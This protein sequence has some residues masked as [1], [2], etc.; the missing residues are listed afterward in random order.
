MACEIVLAS[1]FLQLQD[2]LLERIRT[3]CENSPFSPK[4]I[5][6]PTSTV[7]E[8]CRFA[9][10]SL[11]RDGVLTGVRVVP[12]LQF[13]RQLLRSRGCS[14]LPR[15]HPTLD[16]L[17]FT[18]AKRL[19]AKPGIGDLGSDLS[20]WF[21]LRPTFLDLADGGF[22]LEQKDLLRE[23]A[24][25][26]DLRQI[27]RTVLEL[28]IAWLE[29]LEM[30]GLDWEPLA[31][32]RLA[33]WI[34]EAS[35]KEFKQELRPYLKGLSSNFFFYGFYD[36]TDV[37]TQI[38]TGLGK[39]VRLT[40][41][42]PHA[43]VGK[44]P[45][46][47]FSFSNE[48]LQDLRGQFG[49]S[50][51][52]QTVLTS[53][54]Q[55]PQTTKFF[56]DT[57]PDGYCLNRP[58]FLTV[59]RASSIR[60]EVL[61]A[62]VQIRKW[63]DQRDCPISLN[64][65]LVLAP[66]TELYHQDVCEIFDDFSI[67]VRFADQFPQGN[68]K[69]RALLCLKKLWESRGDPEWLLTL[70]RE[71][72]SLLTR[73]KIDLDD[74]E[75][76]IRTLPLS[77][78]QGWRRL[79]ELLD[80]T[81]L[82]SLP[83][84]E[85][86]EIALIFEIVEVWVAHHQSSYSVEQT[87]NLM[88]RISQSWL[89]DPAPLLPVLHALKT[90]RELFPTLVLPDEILGFLF[91]LP[92]DDDSQTAAGQ[93]GVLF[94]SIMRARGI[95]AEAMVIL[96]LSLGRFPARIEED[97]LLSDSSRERLRRLAL[98]VG[99]RLA[100]KSQ[101]VDEMILLFFL[102]N[103]SARKIHWVIPQTDESGKNVAPTPWVQHYLH[104]WRTRSALHLIPRG[105]SEQALH[106]YRLDSAKGSMLPPEYLA[107]LGVGRSL[108]PDTPQDDPS[109]HGLVPSAAFCEEHYPDR[110][111]VTEL[112][113]LAQ[114]PYRFY[115]EAVAGWEAIRPLSFVIEPDPLEWGSLVHSFFE[116]LLRPLLG[117]G[118]SLKSFPPNGDE[119]V[120]RNA[121]KVIDQLPARFRLLPEPLRCALARRMSATIEAY[122]AAIQTGNCGDGVPLAQE[123]KIRLACPGKPYLTLSG[124][125][126]RV[127]NRGGK[128]HIVD[129]KTGK[130]PWTGRT[131]RDLA[132]SLGYRLQPLLYPW[133]YQERENLSTP[134]SFSFVFL[135]SQPPNEVSILRPER[136]EELLH[137]LL[138]LLEEGNF[139]PTSTELM[140]DWEI[141]GARP[142][143][144][145]GFNSLCR[146]FDLD[147]QHR[148]GR[149][150]Q[151]LARQRFEFMTQQQKP[152]SPYVA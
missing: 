105:P 88:T 142:C 150:F 137:S 58:S 72:P 121:K 133:L 39:R 116:R 51:K 6:T 57:F 60:A 55:S 68:L 67:P 2:C 3:L 111:S 25:D 132:V 8:H 1:S 43:T 59:E 65:I 81:D 94:S 78:G 19:S 21:A 113:L 61:S 56:R 146:R 122:F 62:A 136:S 26:A 141:K 97:P 75:R 102:L 124:Q 30:A 29:T 90:M 118:I 64:E 99:H 40:I 14:F 151:Q 54:D 27:E 42:Y 103:T 95:T 45:H 46:K 119:P 41:L 147:N 52:K 20:N 9:L 125:I 92:E 44:S 149:L 135:G 85:Q 114:C 123:I 69:S 48:V 66:Q 7:A 87:H 28:Y 33:K 5:F 128:I 63:L 84:F 98:T 80:Q 109:R 12:L 11:S 138:D 134:P 15:Y 36:F 100:V 83:F 24:S 107:F 129:Y 140:R 74:F 47:A 112:E 13:L 115:A 73:R 110:I 143:M 22:G 86:A 70:F 32:Q 79:S 139:I 38:V 127:D 152:R 148:S 130:E 34:N 101:A 53:P 18:L 144:Y 50:L 17:L 37:N 31:H 131:D 10:S 89:E 16:L 120:W 145:C 35:E 126:D 77:G 23:L 71:C 117:E 96:G 49:S 82:Q 104:R 76:K 93:A 4:W 108:D 106:L 91:S